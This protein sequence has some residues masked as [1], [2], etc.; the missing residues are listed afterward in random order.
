MLDL[1]ERKSLLALS[2]AAA[3]ALFFTP[4]NLRA[5]SAETKE[6][7]ASTLSTTSDNRKNENRS[8]PIAVTSTAFSAN[9][10]IPKPYTGDGKDISPQL[11]WT[12]GPAATKF[13]AL[14]VEDP[15]APGGTWWHWMLVNIPANVTQLREAAGKTKALPPGA[16]EGKNDF[17]KL[18]YNGPMPP[19][20]Q[21][22]HYHFKIIALNDRLKLNSGYTKQQYEAAIKGH[23]T[24]QGELIGTYSH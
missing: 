23:I 8:E 19:R 2:I 1:Q 13:Y 22:H 3:N 9:E 10:I 4:S 18:G 21:K 6:L 11:K 14:S 12:A 16:V 24:G 5:L 15:D 7:R 17:E 20:G